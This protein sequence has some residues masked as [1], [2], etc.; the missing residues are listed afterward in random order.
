MENEKLKGK[1]ENEKSVKW[2]FAIL[3]VIVLMFSILPAT[4]FATS[5]AN[6]DT[7]NTSNVKVTTKVKAASYKI[8][9]NANGGKIGTQ[10]TKITTVQKGAKIKKLPTTPNREGYSFKG[11]Y[12]KK[13]SGTKITQS[14]KPKK[15]MTYY[16]QWLAKTYTLTFDANGGKVTTT[17]KKVSY[18]KPYSTLPTPTRSGYTFQGWYTAKSGGNKISSTNKMPAKNMAV[19]AQWKKALNADEKKLIGRWLYLEAGIG[20]MNYEFYD[21]GSFFSYGVIASGVNTVTYKYYKEIG[22]YYI[23]NGVLS[24]SY[25][26]SWSYDE[27]STYQPWVQHEDA[28]PITFGTDNK[29]QYYEAD[30]FRYYK[31]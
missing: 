2:F 25:Q 3:I 22:Y 11:W 17:S 8:T 16:A 15:T 12:T 13:S 9:W 20:S 14:T 18:D 27:G 28:Y 4:T 21:D 23:K 1:L 6:T 31:K 29:G 30:D 26:I 10:K 7:T 24:T 5:T 19:Y